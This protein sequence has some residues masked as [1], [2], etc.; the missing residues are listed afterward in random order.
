MSKGED[1]TTKYKIDIS[2]FKKGIK[3]ANQQIKFANAQFKAASAGMDNWQKSST[4]LSSKLQQ[5]N[6]ILI[7]ENK[8]LSAYK[9][10]LE[11]VEKASQENGNR[12]EKLKTKLVEL[13]NNGVKKNSEEYRKYQ[14]AL[15]EVEKEQLGN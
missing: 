3:E 12:A 13:A 4:G 1:I 14:K 9:Q 10:Q 7:N 8:K 2:E 5:L 6:S 15:T 11:A